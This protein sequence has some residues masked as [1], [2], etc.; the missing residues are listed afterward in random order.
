MLYSTTNVLV[1]VDFNSPM[2]SNEKILDN[3]NGELDHLDTFSIP[4]QAG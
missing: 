3:D 2:D 4:G 1:R